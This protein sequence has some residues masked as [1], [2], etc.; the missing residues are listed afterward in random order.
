MAVP[1]AHAT[2]TIHEAA[3][4]KA[5]KRKAIASW[6]RNTATFLESEGKHFSKRF[7]ARYMK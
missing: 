4:M 5:S 1:K 6:L 3:A 7:T 2:V